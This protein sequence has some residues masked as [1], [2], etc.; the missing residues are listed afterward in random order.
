MLKKPSTT[1]LL[2]RPPEKIVEVVKTRLQKR[3]KPLHMWQWL[4]GLLVV[5]L[6]IFGSVS[7]ISGD[8]LKTFHI[9]GNTDSLQPPITSLNVQRTAPYAGLSFTILTAQYATSFA[10][11]TIHAG[12]AI[13]RLHIRVANKT[14]DVPV[15]VYYDAIRLL[16]PN[17]APLAPTNVLSSTVNRDSCIVSPASAGPAPGKS[18]TDCIDF[19][20]AKGT[21][22]DTLSLQL[23]SMAVGESLVTVPFS[24]TFDAS[25]YAD[26]IASQNVDIPYTYHDAHNNVYE[27]VY[28][29][30]STT[31]GYSYRGMQSKAGQEFYVLDFRVDNLSG[32]N[33]TPGFGYDYLRLI[34]NGRTRTPVDSTFPNIFNAGAKN[35]AGQVA[36]V[37]PPGVK[38]I[39][40]GFVPQDGGSLQTHDVQL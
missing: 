9:A 13:V 28:H 12:P 15:V 31:S 40:I 30:T 27:F 36:F 7:V 29:L 4:I 10:D 23:G 33:V 11:D 19:P 38:T 8:L 3:E 5:G 22:L 32:V 17:G 20:V 18:E 6:I 34:I 37:G 1:P 16:V 39:T 21:R 24:G 25:R 2:M 35:V 14:T 26:N